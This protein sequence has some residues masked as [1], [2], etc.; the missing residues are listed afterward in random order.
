[1]IMMITLNH[2]FEWF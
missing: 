1:M 2:W